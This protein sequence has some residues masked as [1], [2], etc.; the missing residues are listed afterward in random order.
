[1]IYFLLASSALTSALK[2]LC[3]EKKIAAV[4]LNLAA[5]D[6]LEQLYRAKGSIDTIVTTCSHPH[7]ASNAWLDILN[8]W[9]ARVPLIA[10]YREEHLSLT[11]QHLLTSPLRWQPEKPVAAI[12]DAL[13][14]L[15]SLGLKK[16]YRDH[17]PVQVF[18]PAF[19][20]QLLQKN[21][22]LSVICIDTSDFRKIAITYGRQT[23]NRLRIIFQHLLS[24]LWGKT[25]GFRLDDKLF[26]SG[27]N[28]NLYY[29]F[30]DPPRAKRG[31]PNPGQLEALCERL[32]RSL[33]QSLGREIARLEKE[34]YLPLDLNAIPY[35]YLGYDTI[36][37]NPCIDPYDAMEML[38]DTSRHT[39]VIQQ[40]RVYARQKEFM[41][42]IIQNDA[43]LTTK[44]QGIFSAKKLTAATLKK[45]QEEKSLAPLAKYI[46]GFEAL[47]RINAEKV[48]ALVAERGPF[49]FDVNSLTPEVLFTMAKIVRLSLELDQ[50][51][52]R[53]AIASFKELPGRLLANIL[54][55]N[56]YH[57]DQLLTMPALPAQITFEVSEAEAIKNY[58]LLV[59]AKENIAHKNYGIAI[60]DFGKGYAGFNRIIAI[61]PH[62]IKLDRILVQG[63]AGDEVRKAYIAGI[64]NAAAVK[65]TLVLA[66]GVETLE[67]MQAL[68]ALGVDLFQ[69]NL[70]HLPSYA[71]EITPHILRDGKWQKTRRK[72]SPQ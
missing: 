50:A 22:Y 2:K 55:R 42:L 19:G 56:F 71:E 66:E 28:N 57:I 32:M 3:K 30:L 41:Q 39:A 69:G 23:Y 10:L 26:H 64:I 4:F 72:K 67:E 65:K 54:P 9:G 44:F 43:F 38:L 16:T 59:Q 53:K 45:A 40:Q 37:D 34:R 18:N 33:Q 7:I 51:C 36:V 6:H 20:I 52:L 61:E 21:A 35:F 60:D 62:L 13:Q 46:Y 5:K 12:I 25:G 17:E 47:T 24:S 8:A 14:K 48:E 70:F 63:V 58:E 29:I 27:Q 31:A 11:M 49:Y 1:M 68:Q 15:S